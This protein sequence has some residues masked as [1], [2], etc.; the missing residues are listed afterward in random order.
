MKESTFQ[1]SEAFKAIFEYATISILLVNENGN[2]LLTNPLTDKL[3]GYASGELTDQC[4]EILIPEEFRANHSHLMKG[5]FDNPHHRSLGVGLELNARKK[6]GSIFPVE[7]SLGYYNTEF[8]KM[9]IVFLSDIT[10]RRKTEQT[11][12]QDQKRLRKI[13]QSISDAFMG[14]TKDWKYLYLN[15]KAITILGKPREEIIGK[16]I[17]EIFPDAL[18]NTFKVAFNKGKTKEMKPF[19]INTHYGTTWWQVRVTKY[20]GG[21]AFLCSDITETKSALEAQQ[22]SEEQFS[23]IFNSS[24][25]A[26]SISE[27]ETAIVKDINLSHTMLYGFTK[28]E[29]VGKT[30]FETGINK[31]PRVRNKIIESIRKNGPIRNLELS[32]SNK[33]G[34]LINVMLAADII[35][36]DDKEYLLIASN[37]ISAKRAALEELKRSEERFAKAFHASPVALSISKIDDGRMIEVNNGFLEL[38]GYSLDEVI[39][40]TAG[41]LRMYSN[42]QEREKTISQLREQG[43]ISNK[44]IICN[45]KNNNQ[46]NVIFSMEMIE[47]HGEVCIITTALDITYKAH[48]EN[49]LKS[50]NDLLEQKV[51]ERTLELTHALEREKELGDM[52]SR[53]V[54]IASHEFRTPLSTILSST[55]LLEKIQDNQ[56]KSKHFNRI[57]S[58]VKN[59]TFILTEF[60]SLD[61]LEQRKVKVEY[62]YFDIYMLTSEVVDEVRE[63]SR[64]YFPIEYEHTGAKILFQDKRIIKN[65]LLNLVSNAAKYSPNDKTIKLK[66]QIN[67]TNI[68]ILVKDH[69]IGIPM[70]DQA[71]I[72]TKFFRAPNANHIQ[73]TG[74][75]L[76]ITKRYV[77]LLGGT[78]GFQSNTDL[79]TEFEIVLPIP[80][81]KNEFIQEQSL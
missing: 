79:G 54:S 24:P 73:G 77:E 56:D 58:A 66:T 13:I 62:E 57:R 28:E 78:I 45:T 2:I 68:T 69:G 22:Q 6:D 51:A 38:F 60:L 53:F 23:V 34:N 21:M 39:G 10:H 43:Y 8:N 44:E 65:V 46:I 70:E 42:P 50:D 71:N 3:F 61:K 40:K 7:I 19:T 18:G 30:I 14:F 67:N 5:Y 20:N 12:Q 49:K 35:H 26:I 63:A 75:G 25:A 64:L 15:D 47:L 11:L 27:I 9:A 1:Y 72:F 52:K 33:R 81:Q 41:E 16:S 37:D 59:L 76:N 55:Y 31:D 32:A 29:Q 17:W 74:L 80:I 36:L 4:I 48:A